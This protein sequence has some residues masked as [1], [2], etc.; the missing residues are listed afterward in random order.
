MIAPKR[1]L[2][3]KASSFGLK[4]LEN[5]AQGPIALTIQVRDKRRGRLVRL[6]SPSGTTDFART[7]VEGTHEEIV[8]YRVTIA[9]RYGRCLSEA[10]TD[11]GCKKTKSLRN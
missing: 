3:E 6:G 10:N 11:P 4:H 7:G 9:F 1:E 2:L 8:A 5:C